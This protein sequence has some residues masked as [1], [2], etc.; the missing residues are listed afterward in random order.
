MEKEQQNKPHGTI[1]NPWRVFHGIQSYIVK[2]KNH[3]DDEQNVSSYERR[4]QF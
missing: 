2:N 3:E 1:L 4:R